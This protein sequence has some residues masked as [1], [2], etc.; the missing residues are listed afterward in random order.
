[1]ITDMWKNVKFVCGNGHETEQEMYVRSSIDS[2]KQIEDVFYACP[3]YRPENRTKGEQPCMNRI[4]VAECEKILNMLADEIMRAEEEDRVIRLTNR[5]YET[6][7]AKYRIL[8]HDGDSI[9]VSVL[10]KKL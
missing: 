7:V 10:N 8:K 3:K 4:S 1:M 2:I 6:N 9:V 5:K